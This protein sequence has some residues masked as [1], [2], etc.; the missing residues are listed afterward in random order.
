GLADGTIDAIATDHAPHVPEAKE[1]PFE[2]APPG[3]LGLET[4][5]ALTLTELVEPGVLDLGRA[6][7]SLSWQPAALA[8]L[9]AHGGPVEPG[10]AGN[11]GVRR[12]G[13]SV[14]GR[15]EPARQPVAQHPLRR[16]QADGAGATHRPTRGAGGR[17]R[18]RAAMS[19]DALLVLSDGAAF[20]G[21]AVGHVP[22]A[23]GAT[24]RGGVTPAPPGYPGV[25]TGPP[26]P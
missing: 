1:R 5:F 2:E 19:R 8:G 14:G 4:A 21:E 7:A 3:M 25:S 18:D 16:P 24:G 23:G 22:E 11:P 9:H 13:G 15:P 26:E 20:E 6:L 17:R 10:R 12:P